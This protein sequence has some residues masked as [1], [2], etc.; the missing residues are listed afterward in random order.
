M[1]YL[2]KDPKN[3]KSFLDTE[4][5]NYNL[6]C[7]NILDK[8]LN[9]NDIYNILNKCNIKI[10]NNI[11][12]YINIQWNNIKIKLTYKYKN[13]QY[14]LKEIKNKCSNLNEFNSII[15]NFIDGNITMALVVVNIIINYISIN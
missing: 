15:S 3:I 14:K 9:I 5:I 7:F 6:T 12:N 11:L 13:N 2:I 4:I 1:E 8:Y 10:L